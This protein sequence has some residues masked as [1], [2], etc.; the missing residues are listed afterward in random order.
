[1]IGIIDYGMGNLQSVKNSCE[2]LG[3]EVRMIRAPE[4]MPGL[5]G[6]IL[7]GVGS[8]TEGME[9]LENRG[10][11]RFLKTA[12]K[13]PLLGICLGMQLLA[14]WGTEGG[15]TQGL[16]LIDGTVPRFEDRVG[17]I[18]HVGW[19]NI[20]IEKDNPLLRPGMEKDYYF[21]HSY[22]FETSPENIIASCEY[23]E[24]FICAVARENIFGVQFHP[25]KS[26]SFGL[27]LLKNFFEYCYAEKKT[28][29]RPVS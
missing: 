11:A 15:R 14:S 28:H 22:H 24:K 1:M 17:R 20:R 19:N 29:P 25:E 23:G 10:F 12:E 13:T 5:T 16:G 27:R 18:P 2:Y 21:V 6:M 26:H 4:D 8:F 3:Q 9:N 7:P